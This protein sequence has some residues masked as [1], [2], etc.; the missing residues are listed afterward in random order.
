[1]RKVT[2][3]DT[4]KALAM[5]GVKA[6]LTADDMPGAAAGATLGEGV[7]ATAQA[8]RGLT[9]EPLYHGEPI[10]AV[11]ATS[12]AIAA[13]AIEAI[14]IEFD[15]L[16]FVVDP[17]ESLRPNGANARTQGNVW[18]RPTAPPAAATRTSRRRC[19]RAAQRQRQELRQARPPTCRRGGGPGRPRCEGPRPVAR[20]WR[21]GAPHAP[22]L[23]VWKWT[24]DD[25][26]NAGEGQ[27]P[28]GKFT[29]EWTFGNVE[30]GLKKADLVLDETFM[31]QSTGHQPL[32]TRTAMAYWQNGKLYLHGSTQSTVQTVAAVARWTGVHA[33][34]RSHIISEYYGGGFGSKIP[35]AISMAI[36]AL[37]SKKANA[38]VMMRITRED[39]HFIGRAR[40][41]ILARVKV[42]FRKDGRI[43]AID[44]YA[45]CDNG[46][47]DAQGDGRSAG[48]DDLARLSA[49]NDA[50]ARSDR[51]DQHAAEDVAARAGRRA[52][53]RHHGAD[54]REGRQEARRRSGR[55]PQDQR[56]APA[57]RRSGPRCPTG[58][59]GLRDERVRQGSARQGPRA[60]S[61]GTR[62]R[63]SSQRR[64]AGH[65]GA[66]HRRRGQPVLR[67][68]DRLRRPVHHQARRPAHSSS[69]ASATSART[70]CS[71]CTARPPKCS[72]CR[73]SSATSSSATRRRTCRGPAS[74]PA[75][76]RRT[77]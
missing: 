10:L 48:N 75:A 32:E 35:G 16:P 30:E 9:N 55:G 52:G 74:R 14:E 60:C 29:D 22:Q 33:G 43:T 5:P 8:E 76:R 21:R 28:L 27:M 42:G 66:R 2:R 39:E 4:S 71:T 40:P 6:I 59:P 44:M 54:P 7:Q 72:A 53:H 31:T 64:E 67:R 18:M 70:R 25:F 17:I 15:P 12:E 62:R 58:Q 77:R 61:S 26:K 57:K 45:I 41:G 19:P 49:G 73:G 11:A 68:L 56:A 23:A 69:R 3:L 51:G 34:A 20:T 24:D 50:V 13:E 37:L 46:P 63:P 47:Y 65:E 38:P 36:P 1:M